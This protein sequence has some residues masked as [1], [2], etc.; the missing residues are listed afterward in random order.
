MRKS[1][2]QLSEERRRFLKVAGT[3]GFTVAALAGAGGTL[4]SERAV[5]QL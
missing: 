3:S 2:D 1:P 5:A 4:F